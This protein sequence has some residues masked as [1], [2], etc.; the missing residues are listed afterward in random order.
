MIDRTEAARC[1]AKAIAYIGCGKPDEARVWVMK[2]LGVL[3]MGDM[4]KA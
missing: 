4:G 3:G 2:L 1:L